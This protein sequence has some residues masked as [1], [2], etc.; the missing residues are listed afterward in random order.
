MSNF[1]RCLTCALL[2]GSG[3]ISASEAE[4]RVVCA[5]IANA[6][7]AYFSLQHETSPSDL[8]S[9]LRAAFAHDRDRFI[10]ST[11]K[12]ENQ[13]SIKK[14][15]LETSE[16]LVS[17]LGPELMALGSSDS[18]A[19]Q[20]KD[21]FLREGEGSCFFSTSSS[22]DLKSPAGIR[23][24]NQNDVR[25]ALAGLEASFKAEIATLRWSSMTELDSHVLRLG[26]LERRVEALIKQVVGEN[27]GVAMPPT[28]RASYLDSIATLRRKI[29]SR[30][31]AVKE[32]KQVVQDSRSR[33][34]S[35][36]SGDFR[37]IGDNLIFKGEKREI[38]GECNNGTSFSGSKWIRDKYWTVGAKSTIQEDGLTMDGAIRK[39]CRGG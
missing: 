38:W 27:G 30:I 22:N 24:R 18:A 3:N 11:G 8:K 19:T 2:A 1:L 31:N 34:R 37:I 29:Q 15:M 32:A 9:E 14:R 35:S 7:E 5:G 4:N 39:A 10:F 23:N 28:A 13:S 21:A 25:S 33:E 36:D 12:A 20:A 16:Q 17:R 26:M 6:A